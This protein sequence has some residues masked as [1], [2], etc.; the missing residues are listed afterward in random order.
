MTVRLGAVVN[1]GA[2]DHS[3]R[4]SFGLA[5]EDP[6]G[7]AYDESAFKYLLAIERKRAARAQR[8]LLVLLVKLTPE[9]DGDRISRRVA[10]R[11]FEGLS[12]ALR[13]VDFVGWYSTDRVIGAVLP[14]VKAKEER[15][16]TDAF[17]ALV[18]RVA[19]ELTRHMAA[20]VGSRLQIRPLLL[21]PAG[22]R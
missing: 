3:A 18:E 1:V 17:A 20:D 9:R 8:S 7:L 21:R 5:K 22:A 6:T 15:L 16:T 12:T 14:V 11:L 10:S 2:P 19:T 4:Q 13:E